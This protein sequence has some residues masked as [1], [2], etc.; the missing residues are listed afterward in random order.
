MTDPIVLDSP[1]KFLHGLYELVLLIPFY[2]LG[3][4]AVEVEV[5]ETSTALRCTLVHFLYMKDLFRV[6]LCLYLYNY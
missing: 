3:V 4:E 5:T 1:L 2:T 6:F